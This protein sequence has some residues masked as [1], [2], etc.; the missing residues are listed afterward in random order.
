MIRIV[1]DSECQFLHRKT[2]HEKALDIIGS[3]K[4]EWAIPLL[5]YM[6]SCTEINL[7]ELSGLLPPTIPERQR[8]NTVILLL[9]QDFSYYRGKYNRK[10]GHSADAY[11]AYDK[12]IMAITDYLD[13]YENLISSR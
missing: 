7:N 8:K 11:E 13:R 4:P 12:V 9:S 3:I 10:Q 1:N 5:G 6:L 2:T